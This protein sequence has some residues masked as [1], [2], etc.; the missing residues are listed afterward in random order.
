MAKRRDYQDLPDLE[1]PE[2]LDG[3]ISRMTEEADREIA[4]ARVN[5]RWGPRQV[6]V[7]KRAAEL[8]GVPYQ[9]YI[10]EAVFRQAL[11]DIESAER[12]GA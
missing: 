7:V 6:N 10:K 2:A 9:T 5:F 1:L 8:I 4:E 11:K 3:R 12:L